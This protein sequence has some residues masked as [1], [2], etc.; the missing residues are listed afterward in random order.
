MDRRKIGSLP[1]YSSGGHIRNHNVALASAPGI[2]LGR[3]GST[4]AVF[5]VTE[6][7]WPH[8]TA[9]FTT[10][11]Y[12]NHARLCFYLMRSFSKGAYSG[13]SAEPAVAK[14]FVGHHWAS[15][16]CRRQ[17]S[18]AAAIERRSSSV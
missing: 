3:C 1:V 15:S 18:T 7:Y 5:F 17:I 14:G 12:D 8:N 16:A 4:D 2:V 9:L 13:K 10:T 11:I 6:P